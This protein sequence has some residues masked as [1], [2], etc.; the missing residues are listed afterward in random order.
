MKKKKI[1]VPRVVKIAFVAVA[2]FGFLPGCKKDRDENM[3]PVQHGCRVAYFTTNVRDTSFISYNSNGSVNNVRET[4]GSVTTY[5]YANNTVTLNK[6]GTTGFQFR[7]IATLNSIG[8]ATNVHMDFNLQGTD[9][10]NVAYEYDHDQVSRGIATLANSG[11]VDT[12]KF[13]WQNGNPVSTNESGNISHY[14]FDLNNP[15]QAGDYFSLVKLLTG[16]EVIRPKNLVTSSDQSTFS[17][18]FSPEGRI[19]SITEIPPF[20]A[21]ITNDFVYECF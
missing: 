18:T 2:L 14:E 13:T 20:G 10:I 6:V 1:P 4:D 17:Y 5:T 12:I 19:N 3:S 9:F 7:T 8:L 21:P 11:F 16:F 15:H